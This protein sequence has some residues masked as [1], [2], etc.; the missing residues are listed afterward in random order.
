M[1]VN[2]KHPKSPGSAELL[3]EALLLPLRVRGQHFLGE[4]QLLQGPLLLAEAVGQ[5]VQGLGSTRS[6]LHHL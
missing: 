1:A 4:A 3:Q 2:R 5:A 6:V